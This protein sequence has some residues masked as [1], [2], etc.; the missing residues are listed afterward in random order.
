MADPWGGSWGA[1]WG[2][3]W[4]DEGEPV[5]ESTTPPLHFRT[6]TTNRRRYGGLW[7]LLLAL[8]GGLGNG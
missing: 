7:A 2:T 5:D 8:F 4:D 6:N 3:S 1:S